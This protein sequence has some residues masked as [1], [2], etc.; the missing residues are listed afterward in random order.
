MGKP[1]WISVLKSSISIRL[2]AILFVSILTLFVVNTTISNHYRDTMTLGLVR[3]E[4]FRASSFIKKSLVV[5]MMEKDRDQIQRTVGQLGAEPGM[6]VI[7]IYNARGEVRFSSQTAEIGTAVGRDADA[8]RACHGSDD[9]P[10]D[11]PSAERAR[12]FTGVDQQRILGIV[13]PILNEPGCASAGC[14]DPSHRVLGVLDVQLSMADVDEAIAAGAWRSGLVGLGIIFVSALVIA[15]IVYEAVHLPAKQLRRG[16]E[17]LAAGN[18]DV[19]IDLRRSD[20]LGQ[21]ARSFNDMARN[22][23]TA[24]AELR[25]WSVTLEDRVREKT[26]ELEDINRQMIQVDRAASLGRMAATVA[27]ELNNP[28]SGIVTYSRVIAR[29]VEKDMPIGDR[30][31][32]VLEE[33]ELIRSESMRCGRIVKDLLTYARESPHEFKPEHLHDLIDRAA[34]L[35]G[36]HLKLGSVDVSVMPDLEDDTVVCDGDQIV[37]ALLALLINA[38]EAMPEGGELILRT[39]P[40]ESDPER[41]VMLAVEDTGCGI[42]AAIRDRIFDPFFSTKSETSGVGLGL[43]VVYGIVSRHGGTIRVE[44]EPE[45]GTTFL[46]ELARVPA[47]APPA[48]YEPDISEWRT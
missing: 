46:I 13:N 43:A 19:S 4:A 24:D 23:R 39:S 16:T 31:A 12:I 17:A 42:P 30:R 21:L 22:L 47:T 44:S 45:H 38:A 28:L 11:L 1:T 2:F 9:P 3:S 5:E 33:L 34:K 20:E 48:T 37:Q 40:G 32:K 7:R 35:A 36:H 29:Q 8:C 41:Q 26:A 18:L 27:H 25:D 15:L 14:H 6:E 10:A